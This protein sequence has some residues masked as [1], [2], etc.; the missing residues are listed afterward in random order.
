MQWTDLLGRCWGGGAQGI[1]ETKDATS[2]KLQYENQAENEQNDGLLK[3]KNVEG[4]K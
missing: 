1:E 2:L 3:F 4:A